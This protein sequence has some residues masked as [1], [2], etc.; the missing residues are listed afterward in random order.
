[1]TK[2][3][4]HRDLEFGD[5]GQVKREVCRRRDSPRNTWFWVRDERDWEQIHDQDRGQL[6]CVECDAGFTKPL[7]H[8]TSGKRF[9]KLL[10]RQ[11]DCGHAVLR[12][13]DQGSKGF[14][15]GLE[16]Q[17]YVARLR[18]IL[19]QIGVSKIL[20]NDAKTGA[21][22]WLPENKWVFEV[23]RVRTDLAGRTEKRYQ[24]GAQGVVWFVP[25]GANDKKLRTE[26]FSVPAVRIFTHSKGDYEARLEPWNNLDERRTARL[27]VYATVV[28][29]AKNG[30]VYTGRHDAY[31]FIKEIINGTRVWIPPEEAADI[32]TNRPPRVRGLWVRTVDLARIRAQAQEKPVTSYAKT[33]RRPEIEAPRMETPAPKNAQPEPTEPLLTAASKPLHPSPPAKEQESLMTPSTS[34][35][36]PP[37]AN[38]KRPWWRRFFRSS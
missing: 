8:H 33:I 9:L 18:R 11:A 22:L 29:V 34:V 16:H 20:P 13:G 4:E 6:I 24:A 12:K 23:Q 36:A 1:M 21:D 19:E 26:I 25:D 2:H 17:F 3:S 37:V 32:L 38:R 31:S 30:D 7:T 35:A 27:T 5:T 15:E 28:R 14:T 10:P